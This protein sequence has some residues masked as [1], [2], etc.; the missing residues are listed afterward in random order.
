MKKVITGLDRLLSKP[1]KYLKGNRVGLVVNH[2]SV[3]ADGLPSFTH[4]HRHTDFQ[5][6][7]LFA[8]EHGLYGVDQDM[9][10]IDH[11]SEPATNTTIISLYGKDHAS[12][13]PE[14]GLMKG[15]DTLVFDIQDI[16]SRYYTFIYTLA[17]CMHTCKKA[18]I[19]I[20]V[21]EA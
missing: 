12:L 17:K 21:C 2:T 9:A 18:E 19:P 13:T 15:I 16:G 14:P 3:A 5:L 10:E 20:V 11:G 7:K 1:K 4:F 8:P 6:I